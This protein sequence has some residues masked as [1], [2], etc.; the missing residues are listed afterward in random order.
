MITNLVM[1]EIQMQK[2]TLTE[3]FI[4]EFESEWERVRREISR[5][6]IW[7]KKDGETYEYSIKCHKRRTEASGNP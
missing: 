5:K 2:P 1:H 4:R 6:V 3:Q 7:V